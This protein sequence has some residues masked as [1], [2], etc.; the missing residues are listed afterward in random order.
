M[1]Y[2]AQPKKIYLKGMEVTLDSFCR[3]ALCPS[4]HEFGQ[5]GGFNRLVVGYT[6]LCYRPS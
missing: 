1:R 3:F 2:L 5:D 4:N 6:I